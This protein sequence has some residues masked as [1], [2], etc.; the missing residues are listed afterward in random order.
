MDINHDLS[1][2]L[3]MGGVRSQNRL[4][5]ERRDQMVG[6]WKNV[7]KSAA[8]AEGRTGLQIDVGVWGQNK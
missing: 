4:N 5:F 2:I 8:N 1:S 6:Q 7:M 3:M